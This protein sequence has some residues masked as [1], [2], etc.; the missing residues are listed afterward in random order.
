MRRDP[1]EHGPML[2]DADRLLE[3]VRRMNADAFARTFRKGLPAKAFMSVITALPTDRLNELMDRA[4]SAAWMDRTRV[5]GPQTGSAGATPWATVIRA[6]RKQ[7][8]MSQVELAAALGIQQSSVSRGAPCGTVG[9]E[10]ND[11]AKAPGI[12]R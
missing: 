5:R 7:A 12:S 2:T 8:G 6:A 4:R 10:G 1:H 9:D 11:C 3:L